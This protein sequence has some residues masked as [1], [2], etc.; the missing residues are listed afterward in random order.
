[1]QRFALISPRVLAQPASERPCRS[2]ILRVRSQIFR[3][4]QR[5]LARFVKVGATNFAQF[6]P[7]AAQIGAD[8]FGEAFALLSALDL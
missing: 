7:A 6:G 1:M 8:M 3:L 2:S 4:G 5:A